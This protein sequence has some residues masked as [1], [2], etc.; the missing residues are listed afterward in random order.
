MGP[1]VVGCTCLSPAAWLAQFCWGALPAVGGLAPALG[2]MA[3]AVGGG[4]AC[5]STQVDADGTQV[6]AMQV[7]RYR[8]TYGQA[9][10]LT[11]QN[12]AHLDLPG[13]VTNK[14][15]RFEQVVTD[16]AEDLLIKEDIRQAMDRGVPVLDLVGKTITRGVGSSVGPFRIVAPT[17]S[18]VRWQVLIMAAGLCRGEIWADLQDLWSAMLDPAYRRT[19]DWKDAMWDR[20]EAEDALPCVSGVGLGAPHHRVEFHKYGATQVN[21]LNGTRRPVRRVLVDV[22]HG[23]ASI[24]RED[25]EL[26]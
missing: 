12:H 1:L 26:G 3:A 24:I 4:A 6:D 19:E 8:L 20:A 14:R 16:K 9:C 25:T 2:S 11:G 21:L 10:A 7:K 5:P 17:D 23:D 22:L 13:M 15:R 18:L